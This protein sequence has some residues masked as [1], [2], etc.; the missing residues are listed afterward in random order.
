MRKQKKH[1][2]LTNIYGLL[3]LHRSSFVLCLIIVFVVSLLAMKGAY[4]DSGVV[5][6]ITRAASYLLMQTAALFIK[7]TI[8]ILR[9]VIEIGGYNGF[10][11]SEAVKIGWVMVRDIANMFF[12]VILLVIAFATIL[13]IESYEW[14]KLLMKLMLAAVLVNFSRVICGVVIDAAQV[15]MITFINGVAATAGGNII[16]FFKLDGYMSVSMLGAEDASQI[17]NSGN[18]FVASLGAVIFTT[19]TMITMGVYLFI[20][21][22]RMVVLWVLIVLSP[23]AFILNVIP[24]TQK[25]GQQWLSQFGN[26]VIVGP[27]LAFFLWLSFATL[28]GG[29]VHSEVARDS[30]VPAESKLSNANLL[31]TGAVRLA[32]S[33]AGI[34]EAMTWEA[35]A[36]L[37]IAIAILWVGVKVTQQL[38]VV[39]GGIIGGAISFGKKV[40]TIATGVALG[41]WLYDKGGKG[42]KA[43]GKG[44][45][46][47]MYMGALEN[48]V[49]RVGN[50][51][52]TQLAAYRSKRLMTGAPQAKKELVAQKDEKG[53]VLKDKNGNVKFELDF[54]RDKQGNVV[55]ETQD[56]VE[57]RTKGLSFFNIVGKRQRALVSSEKKREKTENDLKIIEELAKAQ[58]GGIPQPLFG[59]ENRWVDG[60]D[61]VR[62]GQLDGEKKR[63][64][65]KTEEFKALGERMVYENPRFKNG[66]WETESTHEGSMAQRI[67][68]HQARAD[69]HKEAVKDLFQRGRNNYYGGKIKGFEKEG[70]QTLKATILAKLALK[71]EEQTKSRLDSAEMLRLAK[72]DKKAQ[73]AVQQEAQERFRADTLGEQ[74]KQITKKEEADFDLTAEGTRLTYEKQAAENLMALSESSLKRGV[75]EAKADMAG[76]E[77][78][79][80]EDVLSSIKDPVERA[81]ISGV[82]ENAI[83]SGREAYLEKHKLEKDIMVRNNVVAERDKEIFNAEM[84][85]AYE[86]ARNANIEAIKL[87]TQANGIKS[88]KGLELEEQIGDAEDA[89]ALHNANISS[90]V[91]KEKIA[92]QEKLKEY[93]KATDEGDKN[94]IMGEIEEIKDE[95]VLK[96]SKYKDSFGSEMD[97][98]SS[99]IEKA[100]IE[101]ASDHENLSPKQNAEKKE[102][103]DKA[104]KKRTGSF[105][106]KYAT[107]QANAGVSRRAYSQAHGALL[108]EAEQ[109]EIYDGLGI[110]LPTTALTENIEEMEKRMSEVDY[111]NF[112]DSFRDI[113]LK[114]LD[115][116]G[117]YTD[118]EK[119]TYMGLMKHGINKCWID[120]I[121]ISMW[122]DPVLKNKAKEM[123]NWD[124]N[125][126]EDKKINVLQSLV[127]TGM[128]WDFAKQH[129]TMGD[130]LDA[131][132]KHG[133]SVADVY[134]AMENKG[135]NFVTADGADVT[136]SIKEKVGK[137]KFES[138]VVSNNF[139]QYKQ[140]INDNQSQFQFLTELREKVTGTTHPENG[141]HARQITM[142]NGEK[143]YVPVG[144]VNAKNNILVEEA[145]LP[146]NNRAAAQSHAYASRLS[147]TKGVMLDL[148][149]DKYG[150]MRGDISTLSTHAN[151]TPRFLNHVAG[152][153]S[154]E[155]E[156]DFKNHKG[157]LVIGGTN[158]MT[159]E[160]S[161]LQ[162]AYMS[163][164]ADLYKG[165]NTAKER[166]AVTCSQFAR[167]VLAKG[168][169]R[170]PVDMLMSLA[171]KTGIEPVK[172]MNTGRMNIDLADIHGNSYHIQNISDFIQLYNGGKFG[173]PEY[174]LP[175][176]S[177]PLE[178]G[179]APET[180]ASEMQQHYETGDGI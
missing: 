5:D 1:S 27:V 150:V 159:G 105:E 100:R 98:L 35:M 21:L 164:F 141:G 32:G 142:K 157:T 116:G 48:R 24:A 69:Q 92:L 165:K 3:K 104:R 14:K 76:D 112:K 44:V 109:K 8:F 97:N 84:A 110:K 87:E 172:A 127:A 85:K 46:K 54:V 101:L 68:A 118:Q 171:K 81:A 19:M 26:H 33:S 59:T 132:E 67:E 154:L 10:V 175:A 40:A 15:V 57:A 51:F 148:D 4:A 49:K 123:F 7:L 135:G 16:K 145:K 22:S 41:Q 139:A 75:A 37:L 64:A 52:H 178:P 114:S 82:V 167:R 102:L 160:T 6:S 124:E 25:F 60:E 120:D 99:T 53:N 66:K 133:F 18:V 168:I 74:F 108:S 96:Q 9:Y 115:K 2:F 43:G 122:D 153:S 94:R 17:T 177:P 55:M 147:E 176:Y 162:E 113:L 131:G 30:Q 62:Q 31:E 107:A 91:S 179:Q 156:A 137:E 117:N 77:V 88:N 80:I 61:R 129:D 134:H 136:Q 119:A 125:D 130:V 36:N 89:L 70:E 79:D 29:D 163:S 83:T 45:G 78:R 121:L 58:T 93:K 166:R 128:D 34:T 161:A 11:D 146:G 155:D 95:I 180:D 47:L 86:T 169:R 20:L 73:E 23:L 72:S 28:S 152:L 158:F 111:D 39:G 38:S 140:K 170:N 56:E 106:W 126:F 173:T 149:D 50:Y 103:T 174:Q 13:G 12:V 138:L 65:A 143:F 144:H 151:T 71:G 42:L 63:S 90:H